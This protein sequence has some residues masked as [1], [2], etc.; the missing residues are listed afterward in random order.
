VENDVF[1]YI[2]TNI[3]SRVLHLSYLVRLDCFFQVL[4]IDEFI[5]QIAIFAEICIKMRYFY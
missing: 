2:Y 3:T 4:L 5:V 1:N